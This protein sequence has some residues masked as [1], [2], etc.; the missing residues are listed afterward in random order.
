[1]TI[2]VRDLEKSV[3]FYTE[4]VDLKVLRKINPPMGEIVFLANAEG[5]TM[6]ELLGF[7]E[8]EKVETK[9]LTLS[10]QAED[11]EKVYEKAVEL[12]YNPSPIVNQPPKPAH[13]HLEDPDGITVEFSI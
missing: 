11:L 5:E 13:F 8:G 7:E 9:S 10:F 4:L 1:M 2:L 12:G 6:L 3:K